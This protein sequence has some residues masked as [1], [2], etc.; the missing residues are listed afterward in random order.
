MSTF[1]LS[2]P[3]SISDRRAGGMTHPIQGTIPSHQYACMS[4]QHGSQKQIVGNAFRYLH[5]TNVGNVR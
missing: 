3:L 1:N 5:A 2:R 4:L